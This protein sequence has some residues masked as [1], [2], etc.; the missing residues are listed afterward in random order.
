M[1]TLQNS[2]ASPARVTS[3]RTLGAPDALGRAPAE[4]MH[5]FPC[6]IDTRTVLDADSTLGAGHIFEASIDPAG[7]VLSARRVGLRAS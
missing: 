2:L 4:D 6:Y 1:N 3:V 7:W 5:G